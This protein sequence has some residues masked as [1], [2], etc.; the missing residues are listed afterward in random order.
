MRACVKDEGA[1]G[2]PL[3]QTLSLERCCVGT[4]CAASWGFL[5]GGEVFSPPSFFFF[6]DIR[7]Q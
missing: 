1:V 4:V 5:L 7:P 2:I 6:F 3:P